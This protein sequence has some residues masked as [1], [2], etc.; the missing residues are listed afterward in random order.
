LSGRH[1]SSYDR[2]RSEDDDALIVRELT[3]E[4]FRRDTRCGPAFP[5]MDSCARFL[6]W[7]VVISDYSCRGFPG[8]KHSRFCAK[9]TR[10]YLHLRFREF[11]EENRDCASN[12]GHKDYL[13]K[14]N[15]PDCSCHRALNPGERGKRERKRLETQIQQLQRFEAIGTP[16]PVGR[17]MH[18]TNVIG[19]IL[20]LAELGPNRAS[21][22]SSHAGRLQKVWDKA[23]AREQSERQLLRVAAEPAFLHKTRIWCE[24]LI[25]ETVK[26]LERP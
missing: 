7:D 12:L 2:R 3:R 5:A 22:R 17:P 19:A 18:V 11:G 16:W 8:R 20:G 26:S 14:A 23:P 15:W 10:I 21:Q 6:K 25:S 24:R 4:R 9:D 13:L 1:H